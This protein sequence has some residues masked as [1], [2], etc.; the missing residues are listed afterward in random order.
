MDRDQ[1]IRTRVT[2]V[3]IINSLELDDILSIVASDTK[4]VSLR[5]TMVEH[6][7][8]SFPL[9][10]ADKVKEFIDSTIG[11]VVKAYDDLKDN[12]PEGIDA[13]KL[14]LWREVWMRE[15]EKT[16]RADDIDSRFVLS[17]KR[18]LSLAAQATDVSSSDQPLARDDA[19]AKTEFNSECSFSIGI[20]KQAISVLSKLGSGS[21][22]TV[23][24]CQIKGISF[25]PESVPWCC[26]EFKGGIKSQLKNFGIESSI[27]LLH[28]GIVRPIAHTR[29]RP[30]MLI[31]P[32]Y[33]GGSLGDL[34][35]IVPYPAHLA[36][37][38][39]IQEGRGKPLPP[40]E[41]K[42][43]SD[44][45]REREK[46]LCIYAPSLIHA[47]VQALARAHEEYIL[48]NDLHP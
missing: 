8:K 15:K 29:S 38:V 9:L 5:Q 23:S 42:L 34:L 47:F 40:K 13:A 30:W 21:Y 27:Q 11:N 1:K 18:R 10:S 3:T 39:A 36:R 6:V 16:R 31:F 48:H 25:L 19:L 33:N 2:M 37:V 41:A 22:G 32:F 7:V 43:V 17:K 20:P 45:E 46:I 28:P 35:E 44:E 12:K 26:K 14:Q 4:W 24:K